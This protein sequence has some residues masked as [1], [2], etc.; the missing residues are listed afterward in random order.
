MP[1]QLPA[2]FKDETNMMEYRQIPKQQKLL[3]QQGRLP[4]TRRYTIEKYGNDAFLPSG[5]SILH[6]VNQTDKDIDP[7]M[8]T[9]RFKAD[10][11]RC[12]PGAYSSNSRSQGSMH[13]INQIPSTNQENILKEITQSALPIKT[14]YVVDPSQHSIRYKSKRVSH[15]NRKI[16]VTSK[17]M[18]KL[19]P[20]PEGYE[21]FE[22]VSV[23]E[24]ESEE[25]A[26]KKGKRK[27]QAVG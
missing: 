12:E 16:L 13:T 25:E 11:R 5:D 21:Y 14:P 18:R 2:G 4:F 1:G 17:D 20:P 10:V 24:E 27:D 22:E 15:S 9:R 8:R 23:E 7:D 19:P 3:V 6:H 26:Q